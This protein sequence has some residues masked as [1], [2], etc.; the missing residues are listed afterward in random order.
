VSDPSDGGV[1]LSLKDDVR[2]GLPPV[3]PAF[4]GFVCGC[5]LCTWSSRHCDS[6]EQDGEQGELSIW[7]DEL[8]VDAY[9]D[10]LFNDM[11]GKTKEEHHPDFWRSAGL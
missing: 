4:D 2:C 5:L 11:L 3:G 10:K 9:V 8:S 7:D 1:V 6:N